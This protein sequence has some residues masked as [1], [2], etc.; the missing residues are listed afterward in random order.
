MKLRN[1]LLVAGLC[2]GLTAAFGADAKLAKPQG[3][4]WV[5][6]FNGKDLTG[7]KALENEGVWSVKDKAIV[8]DGERSH[9]FYTKKQCKNCEFF[10]EVKLNHSGNS[11]MYFRAKMEKGWPKGYETQVENTSPDPRKTGSLYGFSDIK[12][13]LVQDDTWWTQHIIADGNHIIV[14]INGKTVTDFVDTKNT[15]TE[16]YLALQQHNKGSV[17]QYRNLMMREIPAKK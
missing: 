12:E 13:Q 14:K 11:G 3:K 7:W 15:Y 16:G 1:T 10:A 2:F 8:G 5:K 17:V 6:I 4:G 9:L